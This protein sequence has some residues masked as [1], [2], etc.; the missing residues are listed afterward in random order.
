LDADEGST[1]I[2]LLGLDRFLWSTSG[3]RAHFSGKGA[4]DGDLAVDGNSRPGASCREQRHR[5]PSGSR[6]RERRPQSPQQKFVPRPAS[7]GR[8]E[9]LPA[10]SPRGSA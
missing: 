3:Q 1:L 10:S 2:A 7:A 8:Y 6:Q 4:L 9:P 5:P